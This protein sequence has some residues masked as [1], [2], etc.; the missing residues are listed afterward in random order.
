MISA[1]LFDFDGIIV[2]SERLH[3]AAFNK[4]LGP[5]GKPISWPDYVETYIGFDDRDAFRTVFPMSGKNELAAL[6]EKKA[7]AF[8]DLLESDGAAALPGAVELI[9]SLSGNIPLA[10]CS[11]ALHE[12]I[13]PILGKLGIE[14]AFD[15]IVTADDTHISKPDPAP[16]SKA[17][18]RLAE[19]FQG[20]ETISSGLAIE[21]TPA[22]IASAKGAGLKVLAVTN[23]Y[24]AEFLTQADAVVDTLEGLTLDKL[25]RLLI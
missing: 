18:N 25:T 20:L 19:I 8:Q 4:V 7:A 13:L 23:S 2:D 11:G 3:W 5:L 1:I 17:W 14:T 10:I 9:K 12:D 24:D 21:D 16:Y 15:T 6:I 22:G